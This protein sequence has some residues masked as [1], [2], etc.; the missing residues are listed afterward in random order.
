MSE[1]AAALNN[2]RMYLARYFGKRVIILLD[3]YDTQ[4]YEALSG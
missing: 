1:A 3:E 2:M 4:K